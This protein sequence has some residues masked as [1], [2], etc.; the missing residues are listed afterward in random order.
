MPR[1]T[2]ALPIALL[3]LVVTACGASDQTP[4]AS[5]GKRQ[6]SA[7]AQAGNPC[8]RK[9]VGEADVAGIMTSPVVKREALD[10]DPQSCVF[11][12]ALQSHITVTV[13]PGLGN[14]TVSA[15][16]NG[17]TNV[18]ATPIPGVGDRAVW[19]DSL[20]EVIATKNNVLCDISVMGP[21]GTAA[22]GAQTRLGNL[23][24]TIFA[25]R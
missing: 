14:V 13:R 17:Q 4:S 9:L 22:P 23:C 21:P 10:G 15:W 20:N 19:Q 3:S 5:G 6:A 12:T 1:R 24:N 11:S 25:R 8:E 16:E 2:Y 18:P 7:A